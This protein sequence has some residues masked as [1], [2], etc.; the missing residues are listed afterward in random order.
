MFRLIQD[1]TQNVDATIAVLREVGKDR[2]V[3]RYETRK[4]SH[5]KP[6]TPK[7]LALLQELKVECD[8]T[9]SSREASQLIE[10]AI[11]SR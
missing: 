3:Q 6:A 10:Q 8:P 11:G 4:Q 2:R 1:H 9:I 7:Q 5:A